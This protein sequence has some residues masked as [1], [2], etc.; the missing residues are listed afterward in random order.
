MSLFST[1]IGPTER[2]VRALLGIG[3]LSL[4]VLG[5]RTPWAYLGVIPLLTA[6]MGWC[7][8]YRMLGIST[9][10]KKEAT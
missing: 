10:R 9:L 5:P 6:I 4:A 2:I 1:N 7:P 3:I 8:L